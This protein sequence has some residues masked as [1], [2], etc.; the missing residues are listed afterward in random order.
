MPLSPGDRWLLRAALVIPLAGLLLFFLLPMATI[1][2]RSVVED[3]G[4]IG[5]ANYVALWRTPGVWRALV[6]SLML[7][8]ATTAI[9]IVLGVVLAYGMERT[10]MPGQR[11]LAASLALPVLA[12]SLV[13]GLGLIFLLGRNGLL[14]KWLGVRP[15]VYGFTGLLIADVMYALPQAVMILRA[16]LR[17]GDARQYEAATV[18]GATP[19]RQFV[20]ITLPAM[21]YGL[22]S[23][24]FVVFTI[25]I[26]DFGNAVVIGGNYAVLA[27]EIY[28]QVSGQ[29]KFGLGAVVGLVL[30]LPAG[31]SVWIEHVASR[32]VPAGA[33]SRV[34][35]VPVPNR[36]RDGAFA[37]A[38]FAIAGC[39][40]A[41]IATV[42]LG[43]FMRLWPYRLE[44][45]LKHY[46]ITMAGGYAPLWTSLQVSAGAA[47]VGTLLL[48][49]LAVSARR[50]PPRA[51]RAV[52]LLAALPVAVPGLVL[53][54]AYVFAFNTATWPWGALYGSVALVVLANFYHY[55]TQA[56]V[57]MATGVRAVPAP[58]EEAC[59]V[60]GG[61]VRHVLRDV[62]VPVLA[63]TLWAVALFLFMRSMVTL[64]AVI[65][66]VT[67]SL[68]LG[69]V[70]VMRLDEAGFTSQAAAFSTCIMAAVSLAAVALHLLSTRRGR[71][72]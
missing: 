9:C 72:L 65:F 16:A 71:G 35:P 6:H 23:A 49:L 57:T 5:L 46:D 60:L 28:N 19:W 21:R 15:E 40:V 14:G 48:G 66:L 43:S 30:L 12:P 37:V 2:W 18:L 42:V 24:A 31:L 51:S 45:T 13:L 32:Q 67:P 20:D 56:Y 3:G 53:G 54:I 44:L 39:A 33:E 62:F 7:G 26:T 1:A 58:L 69:A 59:T 4:G 25:T 68:T 61:G 27:T 17:H 11:I 50:L 22:L 70:T 8:G 64:S 29:M 34:P 63:P 36:L 55:H 38:G 10:A 47:A 41:V 52:A